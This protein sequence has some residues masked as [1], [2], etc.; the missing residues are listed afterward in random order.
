MNFA[1]NTQSPRERLLSMLP[2]IELIQMIHVAVKLGIPDLLRNGVLSV[3]SLALK[4]KT[5]GPTLYR[6]LRALA[7]EGIFNEVEPQQF[8]LSPIGELLCP[9]VPE[10]LHSTAMWL[11]D[12]MCWKSTGELLHS[13]KTGEPGFPYVFGMSFF[14]F[15]HQNKEAY[16]VFHNYMTAL[17]TQECNA[18]TDYYDFS[19]AQTVVDIGGSHGVLLEAILSKYPLVQGVLFDTPEVIEE[20]QDV[21]PIKSI[22][23]ERCELVSGSFFKSIPKSGDVYILKKILHDWD[24]ESV[25]K[26]L[27]VCRH[28]MTDNA[29][30]LVVEHVIPQGN[31]PHFGKMLDIKML[32]LTTG[33]E[34]TSDEYQS[35]LQLSGFEMREIFQTENSINIIEAL[36]I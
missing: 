26:I 27:R 13:V 24:D 2:R 8:G 21:L 15:I 12:P 14:D 4:T 20:F 9:D 7:G 1:L 5:H 35:L 19:Q 32:T 22:L 23:K 30:L 3:E 6:V 17:T 28:S 29:K 11:G 18:I 33:K 10:S 25:C 16:E 31:E 34:R 36:P